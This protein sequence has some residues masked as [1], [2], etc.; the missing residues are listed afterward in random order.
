[1]RINMAIKRNDGTY[2]QEAT[3]I[4]TNV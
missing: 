4:P 3:T 1:M 2:Y